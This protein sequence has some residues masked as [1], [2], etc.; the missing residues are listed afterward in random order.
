M[1]VKTQRSLHLFLKKIEFF[2]KF[3]SGTKRKYFS[4]YCG[5]KSP[6]KNSCDNSAATPHTQKRC[7]D[8]L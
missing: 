6:L 8:S 5:D 4:V 3:D 2:L 1:P 7:A